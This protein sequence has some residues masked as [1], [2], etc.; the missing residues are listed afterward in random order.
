MHYA[1][2]LTS[3]IIQVELPKLRNFS[4]PNLFVSTSTTLRFIVIHAFKFKGIPYSHHC[5]VEVKK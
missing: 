5:K 1:V 2:F 4:M 3:V